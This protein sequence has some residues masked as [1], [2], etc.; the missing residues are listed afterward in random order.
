MHA[1]RAAG[2]IA[3]PLNCGVRRQLMTSPLCPVCEHDL[4]FA[5]S[6]GDSASDEICSLC[7][8]QFGYNDARPDLRE[9]VYLEWRREWIAN[10]RRPFTGD[11]WRRV[12]NVVARKAQESVGHK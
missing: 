9:A 12:S 7:G 5:P 4:G 6:E 10:R 1:R 11:E 3:R 8:I 2:G